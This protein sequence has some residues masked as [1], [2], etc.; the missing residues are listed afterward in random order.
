LAELKIDP[1]KTGIKLRSR[2]KRAD[3][4]NDAAD[5]RRHSQTSR[6]RAIRG[7]PSSKST[8]MASPNRI[9]VIKADDRVYIDLADEREHIIAIGQHGWTITETAPVPF[10]RTPNTLA[11]P[12]PERGGTIDELWDM[13]D[14]SDDFF[15]AITSWILDALR[16]DGVH[17]ILTI[18]SPN[19]S[20]LP[21][22]M[23]RS[24]VDPS[25]AP[26]SRVCHDPKKQLQQA[27]LGYLFAFDHTP[28][29]TGDISVALRRLS[30]G[31]RRI[32]ETGG[33]EAA[34]DLT[35]YRQLLEKFEGRRPRVLGRFYD[36]VAHG[37][38]SM[39]GA[40]VG[41]LSPH[42]KLSAWFEACPHLD[43]HQDQHAPQ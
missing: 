31:H 19:A 29:F 25:S 9:R 34:A 43:A 24:L 6:S 18:S 35:K 26:R 36:A 28:E 33:C 42:D 13:F 23:L 4:A 40:S 21:L 12:M 17:P 5:M 11:L 1:A 7:H 22:A 8:K 15:I 3:F 37:L 39:R 27:N 16:G 14:V 38:R 2:L 10:L 41:R 32:V 30:A 20:M